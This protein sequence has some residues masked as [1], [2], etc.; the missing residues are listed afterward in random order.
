MKWRCVCKD[1]GWIS[2]SVDFQCDLE[3]TQCPLCSSDYLVDTGDD[4]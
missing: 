4:G 2:H 1:C 3:F